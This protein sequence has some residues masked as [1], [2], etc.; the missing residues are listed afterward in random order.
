VAANDDDDDE[1]DKKDDNRSLL[2]ETIKKHQKVHKALTMCS[3]QNRRSVW[4]IGDVFITRF[5]DHSTV[6]SI[7]CNLLLILM[8]RG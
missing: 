5:L 3:A 6:P 4:R 2:H 8:L 1:D 7:G